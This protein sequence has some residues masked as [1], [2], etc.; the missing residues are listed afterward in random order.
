LFWGWFI[1]GARPDRFDIFG[2]GTGAFAEA[3]GITFGIDPAF[4][5]RQPP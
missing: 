3:L 2:V 4:G 5:A 1:D